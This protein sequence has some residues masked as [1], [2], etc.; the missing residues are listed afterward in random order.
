MQYRPLYVLLFCIL[1]LHGTTNHAL[2]VSNL[3]KIACGSIC[4]VSWF[5]IMPPDTASAKLNEEGVIRFRNA[6]AELDDLDMNWDKVIGRSEA[7][8]MGLGDNVRRKLGTVYAPP[9]CDLALCSFESFTKSF[10]NRFGCH[11]QFLIHGC[12]IWDFFQ[13]PNHRKINGNIAQPSQAFCYHLGTQIGCHSL[14]FLI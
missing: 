1:L 14:H 2:K 11:H 13:R 10:L 5:A 9:K 12:S 3:K 8:P 6:K 4:A 7:N